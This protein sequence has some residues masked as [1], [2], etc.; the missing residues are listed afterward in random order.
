MPRNEDTVFVGTKPLDSYVMAVV[1]QFN[2]SNSDTVTLK[3]RGRA[4]SRAV[5]VAEV[6]SKRIMQGQVVIESIKTGTE[7]ITTREGQRMNVSVIEIT[8]KKS[9]V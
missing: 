5:D 9:N 3:A 8:L 6:F 2:Q 1:M 4:I 7:Q